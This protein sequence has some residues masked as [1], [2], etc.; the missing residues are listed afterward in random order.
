MIKSYT[1]IESYSVIGNLHTCALINK[2][3]SIDWFC[4][5]RIDSPSIFAELLDVN[6]GGSFSI[7]IPNRTI[8]TAQSYLD[9]TAVLETLFKENSTD[10]LSI[11]DFM[12]PKATFG[13]NLLVRKIQN[14]S[15]ENI[16]VEIDIFIKPQYALE[17]VDLNEELSFLKFKNGENEVYLHSSLPLT[18]QNNKALLEVEAHQTFWIII[19]DLAV[20]DFSMIENMYEQTL[21]YWQNWIENSESVILKVPKEY[22]SLLTRSL[23]TL[24]LLTNYSSG[25]IVAAP[26]TSLPEVIGG[27]R[28]WDYRY[29]WIRDASLTIYAL[30]RTGHTLEA[31]AFLQWVFSQIEENMDEYN[32]NE[33]QIMYGINGEKILGE[34]TLDHLEGYKQSKPVR[35]GNEAYIQQQLDVY[36]EFINSYYLVTQLDKTIDTSEWALVT[37]LTNHVCE[38][39]Q[40]DDYGIWEFRDGKRHFTHSKLMCW[41]ALDRAIKIAQSYNLELND[42]WIKNRELIADYIHSFCFDEKQNTFTQSAGSTSVDASSIEMILY[43]FLDY[44]DPKAIGT[45]KAIEEKLITKDLVYRYQR[46]DGLEG[47][48]GAF[49]LCSFWLISYYARSNQKEKAKTL[50]DTILTYQSED[51]LLAEEVDEHAKLQLGNYP[52][53]LSHIGLIN[54]V[55]DVS[56]HMK[57]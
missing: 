12:P 19:G 17:N 34:Q 6:N 22:Q 31:K 57:S 30:L 33:L 32:M 26:T 40:M 15:E 14:I 20:V 1:N 47:E 13:D 18:F 46:E 27:E 2:N 55:L 28:N 8:E 45:I 7:S 39:W 29:C 11:I 25:G 24:K 23:I 37:R 42:L 35:V 52:L 48:E 44:T 50:L 21:L 41:V 10:L 5:P 54:A 38:N 53:A 49:L 36:G 9:S 43:G 51:G 4:F 16:N 56:E 3:S